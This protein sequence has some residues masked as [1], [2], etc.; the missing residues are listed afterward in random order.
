MDCCKI[1]GLRL[2]LEDKNQEKDF[3]RQV[4]SPD[5]VQTTT[6]KP[7]SSSESLRLTSR[8]IEDVIDH[9]MAR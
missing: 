9:S 7:V 4:R 2:P 6:R 8:E 1:R 5:E 3:R